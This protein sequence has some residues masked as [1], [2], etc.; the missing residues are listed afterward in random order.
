MPSQAHELLADMFRVR[1]E[2]ATALLEA[3]NF[4]IPEH[5][6][7]VVASGELNDVVPTEY[8]A[9]RVVTYTVGKKAVFAV[10]VEVQ[11]RSDERKRFSW[12]AYV[13]TLYARLKCPLLLVVV[14]PDQRVADWC[15][16]PIEIADPTFFVMKPVALGPV[17]I[18]VVTDMALAER[19]PA[20]VL[21]SAV[22]NRDAPEP[23]R[24]LTV[25]AAAIRKIKLDYGE[26]YYDP[27]LAVLPEAHRALLEEIV[28]TAGYRSDFARHHEARGE[29]RGEAR[30]LLMI[31]DA[32]KVD[33]P[34]DVRERITTCT[35]IEQL[36]VWVRRAVTAEDVGDLFV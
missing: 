29:A 11:L 21:L 22:L 8:R 6:D 15:A 12:P 7:A 20:L 9:D 16:E 31:L 28:T 24:R 32:R 27:L 35:D 10:I 1:P 33:V 18:P 3:R 26:L 14:C 30:T 4:R 17:Q 34:D 36:D 13:G 2:L 19:N 23:R 25:A 5:D